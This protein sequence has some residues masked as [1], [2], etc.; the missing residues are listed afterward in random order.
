MPYI[1]AYDLRAMPASPYAG[2]DIRTIQTEI[3]ATLQALRGMQ[4]VVNGNALVGA[5]RTPMNEA[6]GTQYDYNRRGIE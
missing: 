2:A 6:L 4:V 3:R 5:I 1:P